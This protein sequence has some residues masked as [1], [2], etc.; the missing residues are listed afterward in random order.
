M[1]VK[2][3]EER[4]LRIAKVKEMI[5]TADKNSDPQAYILA[6]C[7]KF[8]VSRRIAREYI[9]IGGYKFR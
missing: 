8:G 5:S 4:Q 9:I 7:R 2:Q 3:K 1:N 6:I